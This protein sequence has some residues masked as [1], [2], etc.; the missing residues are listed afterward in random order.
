VHGP[1]LPVALEPRDAER[2]LPQSI[3]VYGTLLFAEVVRG[4]T[5]REFP[6][7]G[8][9]LAGFSCRRLWNETYPAII[10]DPGGS[11]DGHLLEGVGAR[12]SAALDRFEGALYIRQ[13]VVVEVGERLRPAHAYVLAPAYRHRI[14]PQLWQPELLNSTAL[15]PYLSRGA[16]RTARGVCRAAA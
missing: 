7:R 5:G 15:S 1:R 13:A 9:R 10:P 8:A 11:T 14:R 12:A 2:A 16:D 6:A 3:F 4:V